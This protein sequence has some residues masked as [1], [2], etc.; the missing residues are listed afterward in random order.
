MKAARRIFDEAEAVLKAAE[1]IRLGVRMHV[2]E[3]EF[4]FSRDRMIRLYRE[5]HGVAPQKGMIPSSA[6]WFTPRMANLHASLFTNIFLSLERNNALSRVELLA[7]AYSL[8]REHFE[9]TGQAV[10]MDVTRAWTLLRF[11][12]EAVLSLLPCGH[13]AGHYIVHRRELAKPH[14]CGF[15]SQIQAAA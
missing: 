6:E 10:L 11:L 8:Y 13:C 5:I 4:A 3:A 15:C 7:R 12:D 1:L 2:L 14:V 9:L